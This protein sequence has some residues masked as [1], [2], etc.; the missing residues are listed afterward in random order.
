AILA[1]IKD[2]DPNGAEQAMRAHI[3]AFRENLTRNM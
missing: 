3:E 2:R 1:A